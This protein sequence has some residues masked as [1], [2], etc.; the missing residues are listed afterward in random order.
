M[1]KLYILPFLVL[2][3]AGTLNAQQLPL[4]SNYFFTPFMFNPA[5]SGLT[6]STEISLIHRQQW[7][8]V[9]GAPTTSAITLNGDLNEMK[10]GYS[11]YAFNDQTDIVSRTGAYGSYAYHV[12]FAE[13]NSVS[14][15]LSAGY[16]NNRI[17]QSAINVDDQ[18]DPLLYANLNN[19]STF[20]INFGVN[21]RLGDFMIGGSIPQLLAPKVVYSDN[22]SSPIQYQLIRHYIVHTQYDLRMQNDRMVLSPFV[23]MRAADGVQPQVD[24]GLMFD[25]KEYFFVGAAFRSNYAVTANA[26]VHLTENLTLGYAYDFS[27]SDYAYTLGASHEFMLSWRFGSSKKDKRLENEIKKIK[28]QQAKQTEKTEEIVNDRLDEFKDEI[29]RD[30]AKTMEEQKKQIMNDV[31]VLYDPNNPNNPNNNRPANNNQQT[32]EPNNTNNTNTTTTPANNNTN[33]RNEPSNTTTIKG[34]D[35]D[36]YASR[37]QPGSKGYYVTAG[38]FGSEN[39]ARKLANNL[40]GQNIDVNVFKDAET[41]MF[42]VFLMKFKSYEQARQ[43]KDSGLNGQYSGKLWVKVVE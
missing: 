8:G 32:T 43:A 29:R 40:K 42:Y 37:V 25:Y 24:A 26:G 39:N 18:F 9:Q 41:G 15:G 30:N 3:F 5:M 2:V 14:F 13:K 35:N 28:D 19:G 20:D 16:L 38:V 17:D 11:V 33:N 10:F 4:Y 36:A 21:L 7:S 12:R 22:F 34:Y 27:T 6:G 23:M 31:M 1:K